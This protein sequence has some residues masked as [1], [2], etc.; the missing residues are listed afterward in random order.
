MDL[1]ASQL[2]KW[3]KE[4]L[5][6]LGCRLNR[7]NNIPVHR[8]KGTIQKGWADL[9]GYTSDGIYCCVEVKK[10]GDKLSAEQI[11]RL[12]DVINCGGIAYICTEGI[13]EPLLIKWQETKY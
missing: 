9:Q 6:K 12:T 13:N 4:T 1:T 3:A 11:D 2:T 5:T 10:L 8:R 7:V